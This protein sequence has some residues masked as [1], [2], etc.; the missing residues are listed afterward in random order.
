MKKGNKIIEEKG[1]PDE[2]GDGERHFFVRFALGTDSSPPL[3]LPDL[4]LDSLHAEQIGK[5]MDKFMKQT[6]E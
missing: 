6:T 3:S 4:N 5:Y 2:L 1:N